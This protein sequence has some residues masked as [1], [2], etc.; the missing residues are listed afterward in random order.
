MSKASAGHHT[1]DHSTRK[2]ILESALRQFGHFGFS[3]V[4]MNDIA[5]EIG[6]G[7]ATL[8]YYFPTKEELFQ[9]V[10]ENEHRQF[11]CS[12]E[13]AAAKKGS[14]AK[15][16]RHYVAMK[17]DNFY[18]MTNLNIADFR[19]WHTVKPFLQETYQRFADEEQAIIGHFLKGGMDA[20]DFTVTPV[21]RISYALLQVLRG[22]RCHFLRSIEG[23][24]VDPEKFQQLKQEALFVTDLILNG[25]KSST[26]ASQ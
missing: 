2:Q 22:L 14:A 16:I 8:Y 1:G 9:A 12:L 7:K 13:D 25:L 20:G 19:N 18:N 5:A 15:K 24:R 6:M 3:K 23:P 21:E 11:I 17:M 26:C 4:T 10:L